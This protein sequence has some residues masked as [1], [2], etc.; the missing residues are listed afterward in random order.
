MSVT[1]F[2]R[3][4]KNNKGSAAIEMAFAI[5][6]FVV[7]T[8]AVIEFSIIFLFSFVIEGAMYNVTRFAKVQANPQAVE[9]EIRDRINELSYGFMQP[10]K[11]IITTDLDINFA[12]DWENAEPEACIDPATS[13]P[14]GIDN[15]AN[16]DGC[17]GFTSFDDVNDDSLCNI[18]APALDME[19][20]GA[21]VTYAAFYKKP[22]FTPFFCFLETIEG[23][24]EFVIFSS[25]MVRNEPNV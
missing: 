16:T 19:A 8:F 14:S 5:L 6:P 11:V 7:A 18:G 13:L 3:F 22:I 1:F 21:I 12:D 23:T 2:R 24:C 15:C 25:T 20:P 10:N 4:C 9:Q 17:S